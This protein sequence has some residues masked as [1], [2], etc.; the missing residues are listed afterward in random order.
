MVLQSRVPTPDAFY[1]PPDDVPVRARAAAAHRAVHQRRD[2]HGRR[3]RGGSSTRRPATRG[4]RR[5]RAGWSSPRPRRRPRARSIA[6]AHGT[7][8]VASGLRA[9]GA[10]RRAGRR[11]DVRAGRGARAGWAMVAADYIGLGTAGP[12]PYLIGQGEG[13]SVLDAV[14]AAHQLTD[15]HLSPTQTV[16][17]G[18]SQG[19]H[20]ALWAGML[21]PTYAPELQIDGVA[22]LAPASNLPGLVD[23]MENVT[24]GELF[25][26]YVVD[27]VH[28]DLPRRHVRRPGPAGRADHRA[29]DGAALPGRAGDPG[30]GADR[31]VSLDK[32]IWSGDP[33]SGPFLERL[34]QNVPSGPIAAP[35]LVG[36][37]ADDGLVVP[38]AQDAYVDAR[39]A[40][41]YA[42]DYRT[43]A[44]RGHVP[45][46]EADSPLVPDLL[47]W[48]TDRFAAAGGRHLSLIARPNGRARGGRTADVTA[49]RSR[50]ALGQDETQPDERESDG[51]EARVAHPGRP[52]PAEP[53]PD[54]RGVD[55]PGGAE[56]RP[57]G[58]P[59]QRALR[60]DAR[61][62]RGAH[63]VRHG[64]PAARGVPVPP[65]PA[66]TPARL[67]PG[68]R[69]GG[70]ARGDPRRARGPLDGVVLRPAGVRRH[71]ARG[72]PLGLRVV[73]GH[74]AGARRRVRP[75]GR[76]R[77][78]QRVD[79]PGLRDRAGRRH[80]GGD[81]RAVDARARR[82]ERDRARAA[83]G[84][85]LDDQPRRGGVDHPPATHGRPVGTRGACSSA[86]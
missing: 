7:T 56:Q 27:G 41:G 65:G 84:R 43:Y 82:A 44:G 10:R 3:R 33:S 79:D 74:V 30:L 83:D 14:R 64:V 38:A 24:G 61:A 4:G 36:Q 62:G 86:T 31:R 70:R 66:P 22:A 85:G 55:P 13:R 73:H 16:V 39:C 5:S 17:W 68:R 37:G 51:S 40:A 45:L 76:H 6:W 58:H 19:G 42:V 1:D 28:R 60:H 12:H 69:T 35:L 48:T 77:H 54:A 21:A 47:A 29:G 57:G 23:A 25:A 9:V 26:S 67:A 63:R 11:C 53:G 20:A 2:P 15:A 52:D 80:A 78:A 8:G 81:L 18:H 50:E 49:A 46:V 75:P 59:R 71:P 72:V 34:V 32:P